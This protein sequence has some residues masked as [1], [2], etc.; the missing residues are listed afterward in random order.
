[1]P[2]A[3]RPSAPGPFRITKVDGVSEIDMERNDAYF[4]GPKGHPAIAKLM[5]HE[6][7]DATTEIT[8]ILS[9]RADWIWQFNPDQF[10][11]ISRVPTLQAVRAESMRI[12]YMQL[13]AAGRTGADNPLTKLKVRRPSRMPSTG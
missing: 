11:N 5:I 12:G 4:D 10:E 7:A 8:E 13:D 6:V 1:M 9:G 3:A 2:I